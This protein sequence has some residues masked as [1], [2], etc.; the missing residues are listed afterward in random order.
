M[1][2]LTY[3]EF[4]NNILETRGRFACGDEYHERHHIVP[5]CMNGGDE[6][7]NLIDL[8]AREHFIAHKMLAEE[9]PDED[10]LVYAWWC[11]SI[12][13]NEYT[14][15]R[16]QLAASEYE[17][18]R[19]AFSKIQQKRWLG[20][21]NP[22]H[23]RNIVGENNPNYGNH[24]LAGEN[25]PWYGKHLT[26]EARK[27][28]SE[29]AKMRTGEKNSNYGNHKLAGENHPNYGNGKPVVQLTLDGEFISEYISANE[30][31]NATGARAHVIRR[32]CQHGSQSAGGY[33]W[34][35][36]DEYDAD[37]EY[38]YCN[39]SR[40]EVVQLNLDGN[41]IAQYGSM[42]EA[43]KITDIPNSNINMC[44]RGKAKSAGGFRWMYKK[45]W[46]EMRN[47]ES[48]EC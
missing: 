20:E 40:K 21:N 1:E 25:A 6:D 44:C 33:L 22:I 8:F 11:M 27:K 48:M 4:I 13:T 7:E 12:V 35:Y 30:A 10:N 31:S 38:K 41:I 24:K 37:K 47:A 5:R 9:N 3:D 18:A 16:Y 39:N 2:N 29:A 17:E 36:K 23:N 32:V 26:E 43:S 46:E 42:L 19:I 28:L 45:D 14:K 34:V 15:E